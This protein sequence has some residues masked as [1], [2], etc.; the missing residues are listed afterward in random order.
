MQQLHI[1][2]AHYELE[3]LHGR[4]VWITEAQ[5]G[6]LSRATA[7]KYGCQFVAMSFPK[8]DDKM[9]YYTRFFDEEG[10]AFVLKPEALRYI[11]VTVTIPTPARPEHS[12]KERNI[13]SDFYSLK[14]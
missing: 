3:P 8:M 9:R 6:A 13:E 2:A 4:C 12:Y 1:A 11:P 10:A 14:I 5:V 7:Q